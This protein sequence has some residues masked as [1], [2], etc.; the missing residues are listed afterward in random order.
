MRWKR[1]Q[2]KWHSLGIEAVEAG[3]EDW[4]FQCS[5]EAGHKGAHYVLGETGKQYTDDEILTRDEMP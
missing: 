1:C 3:M 4:I 2:Q 5:M